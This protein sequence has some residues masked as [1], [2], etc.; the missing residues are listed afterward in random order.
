M[1]FA[2]FISNVAE[3]VFVFLSTEKRANCAEGSLIACQESFV[4]V[5]YT[6][7]TSTRYLLRT[8][9]LSETQF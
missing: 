9:N 7:V 2:P 6:F 4:Q 5:N 8:E 3:I 1:C